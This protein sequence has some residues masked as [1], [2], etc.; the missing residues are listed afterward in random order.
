MTTWRRKGS[1]SPLPKNRTRLSP[2]P[3][4]MRSLPGFRD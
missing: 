4:S 2:L 1:S 3:G